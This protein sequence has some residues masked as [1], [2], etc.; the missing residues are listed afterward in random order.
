MRVEAKEILIQEGLKTMTAKIIKFSATPAPADTA[1]ETAAAVAKFAALLDTLTD[2]YE[3][4]IENGVDQ[5]DAYETTRAGFVKLG[6]PI[7]QAANL[8]R[9]VIQAVG[10]RHGESVFNDEE[11]LTVIYLASGVQ[12]TPGHAA[13]RALVAV[14]K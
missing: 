3:K 6:F 8:V 9:V 12:K 1:A 11:M 4:A 14:G 10:R 5:K 13:R 2:L 7:L